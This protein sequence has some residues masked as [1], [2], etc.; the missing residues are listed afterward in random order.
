MQPPSIPN[1]CSLHTDRAA[2]ILRFVAPV[3]A[4]ATEGAACRRR[5]GMI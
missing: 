3:P 2:W 5:R 4:N 1:R